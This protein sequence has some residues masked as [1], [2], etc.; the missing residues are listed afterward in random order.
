M[1]R[2]NLPYDGMRYIVDKDTKLIHD[3]DNESSLCYID[4]ISEENII[5]LESE[6]DVQILCET[7][8]YRGCHWC[9]SSFDVELIIY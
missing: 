3:L 1:L 8:N 5:M 7:E 6:E 2:Y 9:N 4:N